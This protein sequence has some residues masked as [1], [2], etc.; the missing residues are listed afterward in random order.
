MKAQQII[1]EVSYK[2][3]EWL[4]MAGDGAPALLNEI[5]AS[6]LVK[7]RNK[8]E[9]YERITRNLREEITKGVNR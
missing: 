8:T 3:S 6:L 7:E 9:Y 2:Y 4:E 1:N 5:L